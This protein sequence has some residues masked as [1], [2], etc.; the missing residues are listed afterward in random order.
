PQHLGVSHIDSVID[1]HIV[2]LG[3]A[4]E[5]VEGRLADLGVVEDQYRAV[6]GCAHRELR[7]HDVLIVK[8]GAR[9]LHGRSRENSKVGSKSCGSALAYEAE[10]AVGHGIVSAAKADHTKAG[11]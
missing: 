2:E 6:G 4:A 11:A 3:E 9:P 7:A 1:E 8:I 10:K 5:I